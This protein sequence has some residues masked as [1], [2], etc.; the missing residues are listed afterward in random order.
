MS[1]TTRT[2]PFGTRQ[3]VKEFDPL[4]NA[5]IVIDIPHHEVH[6]GDT[7][8]AVVTDSSAASGEVVQGYLKTPAIST[9][10]KRMHLVL[11][12]A[13]TG[14]HNVTIT[15]GVTYSSGGSDSTP[16]NRRR[17]SSKA[18]AVQA[19]KVGSDKDSNKIAYTGGTVIWNEDAGSGRGVGGETRG[20]EE[21]ILAPDTEYIFE[22]SSGATSTAISLAATWYEHTDVSS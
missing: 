8:S 15:E 20:T 12:H 7:F 17:D 21:W 5:P 19:M 6:E 14:Q 3:G 22:V 11:S 1:R 2:S 18:S 16:V 13:G 10:Q 4:F 9:P